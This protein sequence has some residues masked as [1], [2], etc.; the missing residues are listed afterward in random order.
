MTNPKWR[1]YEEVAAH[2]LNQFSE[3]F[4]LIG[5]EGKQTVPGKLTGT[6]WTIDAKGVVEGGDVFVI[7]EC[8]RYTTSKQD[9]EQLAG[10][11]YRIMDTGAEGA[12]VV[13]PLGF[14]SGAEK[15]AKAE[16]IVHVELHPDSTAEE[17]SMR[18]LNQLFVGMHERCSVSDEFFA[19]LSRPC[20]ICGKSFT[21]R[22]DETVCE[23]CRRLSVTL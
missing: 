12:I 6:N 3:H 22:V 23:S 8:R 21:V 4:N 17:F 2:L 11:A 15:V 16:R 9:Q 18:F 19:T 20:A 13:S 7:V 10:L 1:D 14:Q 5:V